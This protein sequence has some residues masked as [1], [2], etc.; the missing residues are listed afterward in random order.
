MS[1]SCILS[2]YYNMI[3]TCKIT[4]DKEQVNLLE[5]L[6]SYDNILPIYLYFW[7]LIR[8]CKKAG[9]YIY[10]KVGRGKSL[11]MD[12]YYHHCSIKRKKRIHFNNF[13]GEI[14]DLLHELRYKSI[15]DPI[16][17]V[18]KFIAKDI[19]LLCLDEIQVYDI[20]DA[21][22]FSKLFSVL[23]SHN[24]VIMMTSNYAPKQLYEDGIQYESFMP[25]VSLI[26]KYMEVIH[27]CGAQDYR[28][29][30]G[31]DKE[32]YYMGKDSNDKLQEVF[33][34][35]TKGKAC[36]SMIL[37]VNNKKINIYKVCNNA[38][39]FDFQDLCGNKMPLW[40]DDY[41][42]IAKNFMVIFIANVPIFD[43]YNQNEMRRFTILIDELY[44][45][46]NKIFCSF[47]AN[48]NN[49]YYSNVVPVDFQRTISRLNEMRSQAYYN[50]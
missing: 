44:E 11:L 25:A 26:M 40:V 41:H 36:N 5:K 45:N 38:A 9:L 18:A 22:I 21:M 48:L 27:L 16:T 31:D 10:G 7:S 50:L 42:I 17:K 8:D 2:H 37:D 28:L 34:E 29:S 32:V 49:L 47:A 20:C 35:F 23:F 24:I 43:L 33:V 19:D 46:K 15:K 1:R 13:M 39:W 14:H 6:V 4:Y 12:L 30:K 3:D